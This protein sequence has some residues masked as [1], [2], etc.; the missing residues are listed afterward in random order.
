MQ[1]GFPSDCAAYADRLFCPGGDTPALITAETNSCYNLYASGRR[2]CHSLRARLNLIQRQD[3]IFRA[4]QLVAPQDDELEVEVEMLESCMPQLVL[5]V[6]PPKLARQ[7]MK[8][9][10]PQ[11]GTP[12]HPIPHQPCLAASRPA[13]IPHV[14]LRF[15]PCRPRSVI[16]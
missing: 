6:V 10:S 12:L 11:P 3:L 7:L 1:T 2:F 15:R 13:L 14:Q 9:D 4:A 16:P 8:E 5:A